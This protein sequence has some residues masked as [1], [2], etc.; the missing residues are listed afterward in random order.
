MIKIAGNWDIWVNSSQ[1]YLVHWRF[2]IEHFGV[3]E[4]Y[5]TP[6]SGLDEPNLTE[7]DSIQEAIDQNPN[8]TVVLV[9]E[10]GTTPVDQFTHPENVLYIFGKVGW[11]PIENIFGADSIRIRSWAK[12]PNTSWGLLHPHQAASIILH[13]NRLKNNGGISN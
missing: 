8:F 2:M 6:K 7:V 3:E 9:D 11:S 5:M 10:N 13:D 4:I 1:E 12:N